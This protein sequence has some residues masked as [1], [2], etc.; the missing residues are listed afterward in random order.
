MDTSNL[1][2]ELQLAYSLAKKR[3]SELSALAVD[4]PE[5]YK[6]KLVT[7]SKAYLAISTIL[8]TSLTI[9]ILEELEEYVQTASKELPSRS[10]RGIVC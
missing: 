7:G 4:S 3:S 9:P 5:K 1:Q 8:Y 10:L 2:Q 6:I